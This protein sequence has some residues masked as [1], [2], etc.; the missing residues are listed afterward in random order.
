MA[1]DNEAK[2]LP[3]PFCGNPAVLLRDTEYDRTLWIIECNQCHLEVAAKHKDLI[4]GKRSTHDDL[5]FGWNRRAARGD[6]TS[7]AACGASSPGRG[8]P[9]DDGGRREDPSLRSG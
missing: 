6:D 5:I 9:R 4:H 3:C 7:Q 8:E 1:I 2:L